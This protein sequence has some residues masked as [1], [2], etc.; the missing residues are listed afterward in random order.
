MDRRQLAAYLLLIDD[1]KLEFFCMCFMLVLLMYMYVLWHYEHLPLVNRV[2]V[3]NETHI[4]LVNN[5]LGNDVHCI[6]KLRMDKRAF[7]VLCE[8]LR[9]DINTLRQMN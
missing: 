8:L 5:L 2:F 4:S 1:L 7:S 3:R 9:Y 6:S